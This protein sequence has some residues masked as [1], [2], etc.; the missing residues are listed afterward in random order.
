MM[1]FLMRNVKYPAVAEEWGVQGKVL[2]QFVVEKD[3][4]ITNVRAQQVQDSQGHEIVV[5]AY[6]PDMTE[7][8]KKNVDG[9]NAGLQALKDEGV[10]VVKLMPKW[11]PGKQRG[12]VVRTRFHI[13]VTFR[14]Q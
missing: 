14:L 5:V 2:V 12:K 1:E 8:Q 4:S 6:K 3:G 10:R 7:E 9:A 11:K 13:P